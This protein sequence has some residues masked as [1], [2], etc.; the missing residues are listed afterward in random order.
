MLCHKHCITVFSPWSVSMQ[1][2]IEIMDDKVGDQINTLNKLRYETLNKKKRLDELET[3]YHQMLKES[4]ESNE[5]QVSQILRGCH[6]DMSH[7]YYG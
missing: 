7:Y 6:M 1:V 4:Q 3:Q 2:A 5:L